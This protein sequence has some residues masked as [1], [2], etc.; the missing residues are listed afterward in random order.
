MKI[1]I[2]SNSKGKHNRS[3]G[4]LNSVHYAKY[5]QYSE[6]ITQNNSNCTFRIKEKNDEEI[7]L[8]NLCKILH[9][10][11]KSIGPSEC[12]TS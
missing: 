6:Y 10:E 2:P 3:W 7:S 4:T 1:S 8:I 11:L 12:K 5:I 9:T